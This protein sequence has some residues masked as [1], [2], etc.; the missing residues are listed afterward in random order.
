MPFRDGI[1]GVWLTVL[2][3]PQETKHQARR[4]QAR[5]PKRHYM[6]VTSSTEVPYRHKPRTVRVGLARTRTSPQRTTSCIERARENDSYRS[7]LWRRNA[8]KASGRVHLGGFSAAYGRNPGFLG[9]SQFQPGHGERECCF[10]RV[11]SR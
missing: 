8:N 4:G 3:P 1:R 5:V 6:F 7:N 2:R 10:G 9:A 11:A